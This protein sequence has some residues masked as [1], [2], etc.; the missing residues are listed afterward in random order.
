MTLLCHSHDHEHVLGFRANIE[1]SYGHEVSQLR[2][3]YTEQDKEVIEEF[4]KAKRSF[5]Q[6]SE[7]N[8][9]GE[10]TFGKYSPSLS[11]SLSLIGV[12]KA[13]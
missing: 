2:M 9:E 13:S 7:T 6:K 1:S 10:G 11:P 5:S 8:V 3:Q 4:L 12:S